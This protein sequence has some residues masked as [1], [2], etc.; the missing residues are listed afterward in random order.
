MN[1]LGTDIGSAYYWQIRLEQT[2][3]HILLTR[4]QGIPVVNPKLQVDARYMVR[5]DDCFLGI[6]ITPWFMNLVLLPA[7][8][9]KVEA[10]SALPIGSKQTHVF[11]SGPYEFIMGNEEG[12]GSYQSCS[13]FSPM[14]DF[15]D[16]QA[17]LDTAAAVLQELMKQENHE[18]IDMREN[19][20]ADIWQERVDVDESTDPALSEAFAEADL[21]TEIT[22]NNKTT[23]S[24][25][26][27]ETE[28]S[29]TNLV[30]NKKHDTVELSRKPSSQSQGFNRRQLFTGLFKS[31]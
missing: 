20:I 5:W 2:F 29:D 12:L 7:E 17:A 11:P 1:T 15:S 4:M 28:G 18:H 16:Q 10:F 24:N 3:K 27:S 13:L 8:T 9:A 30:I 19:E 25:R 23:G 6:L 21:D 22:E 14:F 26:K 31:S